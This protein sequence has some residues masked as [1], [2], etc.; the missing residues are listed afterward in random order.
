MRGSTDLSGIRLDPS[1]QGRGITADYV[2]EGLR[3][4]IQAGDLPDDSVLNQAAIAAH[5]GVSR[6]P[7][8]E[9]MRQLQAE[10]LIE[11]RAHHLSVVSGLSLDAIEQLY[12]IRALIEGHLIEAATPHVDARAIARLRRLERRM[13]SE[14]NH[15][16]WLEMNAEFHRTLNSASGNLVGLQL[17]DQLKS[18]A[19]RYVRMWSGGEGVHRPREAGGEHVEI[20]DLVAKGDAAG[21]KDAVERHIRRTGRRLVS[22]GRELSASEDG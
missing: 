19:E 11:A 4:A 20:L 1:F 7:V 9:A 21:A 16:R 6:V 5:F 3:N 15:S 17:V 10:G 14:R 2:A 8:R 12:D 13:R 18:R 22:Y